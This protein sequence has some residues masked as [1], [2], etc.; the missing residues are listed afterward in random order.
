MGLKITTEL[1]TD[2]G[3]SSEVYI[4]IDSIRFNRENG[5]FLKLN[6]Y[7]N[8]D[9]KEIDKDDKITCKRL[10]N[11]FFIDVK[12]PSSEFNEL[13][14]ESIHSFSYTKLKEKLISDGLTVEDDL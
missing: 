10:L 2:A 5:V 4:N 12:N 13:T 1:Y 6:N 14:S 7:L 8:K 11:T 9:S 3:A